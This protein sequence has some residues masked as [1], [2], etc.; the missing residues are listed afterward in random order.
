MSAVAA[1][2]ALGVVTIIVLS[3]VIGSLLRSNKALTR[4]LIARNA[5]E[6]VVLDHS[7]ASNDPEPQRLPWPSRQPKP[8]DDSYDNDPIPLGL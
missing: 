5:H 1:V 8:D 6:L 2:A 7:Q 4:A 3:S